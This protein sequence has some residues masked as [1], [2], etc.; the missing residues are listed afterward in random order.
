M[1]ILPKFAPS[2]L[3][4]SAYPV[5]SNEA[6]LVETDPVSSNQP[7]I[8]SGKLLLQTGFPFNSAPGS[9]FTGVSVA[10]LVGQFFNGATYVPDLALIS[11]TG[12]SSVSFSLSIT[13]NVAG[14]VTTSPVS[15]TFVSSDQFGRLDSGMSTPVHPVFYMVETN[16]GFAIG[17]ILNN[18]FFGLFEPQA[19]GSFTASALN[20]D[21]VMGTSSPATSSV[22]DISGRVTL[23]NTSA[24][25]GSI[26]GTQDQSTSGGNTAGQTVT[27]TYAGLN[28][29]TGAG[30][31]AL[32]APSTFS[33]DFLV[34]T[35]T[36][37]VVVSTISS[38]A[39][40]VLIYLGDCAKTCGED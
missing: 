27:G 36:K 5:A 19:A 38:D 1:N 30:T 13:E 28:S 32:T 18:P 25:A 33:G 35:P 2:G 15:G 24:S 26:S 31:V 29:S 22:R 7:F 3:T 21:F 17:E 12:S 14:T 11:L 10:G 40:P 4:Y 39:D 37:I 8:T 9:S 34:V 16:E 6:F 20:G 23:A